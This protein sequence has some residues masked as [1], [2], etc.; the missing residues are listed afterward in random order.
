MSTK[1]G[2]PIADFETQLATQIDPAG[3][4]ATLQSATDDDGVALPAGRYFFTLDIGNS[5]KEHISCTLSGTSLTAIKSVSRQG[6]ETTGAARKH[7]VG[8]SVTITDYAHIKYMNDLLSGA[9]QLD[10]TSPLSYDG[11]ASITTANQLATKAY[12]DATAT[13]SATYDQDVFTGVAGETLVSGDWVYFKA[14]DQRWW[15]ADA[16]AVGTSLA[17]K[18]A[19]AQGSASAAGSL[20]LLGGG[21]IKNLSGLT[22]GASY[23]ISST[24]GS[25]T[26]TR[27]V[28]P[29][30]AR[31]VGRAV[32]AT[33][34]LVDIDNKPDGMSQS[35]SE[36]YAADT[37]GTDTYAITITPTPSALAN[38]NMFN[39]KAGTSN[40]GG[41][42]LNVNGLGA[43]A[44]KKNYNTALADNDI[45][46]GQIVTVIYDLSNDCFQMQ[47]Q[48][49]NSA[50]GLLTTSLLATES[51]SDRQAVSAYYYQADGGVTFDAK[52]VANG[53]AGAA[54]IAFTVA[55]Q[56]NRVLVVF[57]STAGGG[58]F[59]GGTVAY[60]GVSMTRQQTQTGGSFQRTSVYTLVAPA[61]GA[62][63]L[64]F[65]VPGSGA[66]EVS[67]YS[68]YNASQGAID[69]SA[70]AVASTQSVT[71]V[72]RGT[73]EVTGLDGA[74][75]PTGGTNMQNNQQTTSGQSV[76]HLFTGDSGHVVGILGFTT[77]AT[78]GTNVL[79]V[80]IAPVT[81]PSF[82]YVSKSS[83]SST[84]N[85]A[86]TNKYLTFLG[87]AQ[88][89]A[90]VGQSLMV[91]TDGIVTGLSGLTP[92]ATYFLAD[93]AGTIATTTGTNSKKIGIAL[94]TTTLLIKHDNS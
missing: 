62:N 49:A 76:A 43:K 53:G 54:S 69:N 50:I 36:I 72:A 92:L 70:S 81:A 19:V 8:A 77:A 88:A 25:I 17:V 9:T 73:V 56:S 90:T 84:T 37:V 26:A 89:G 28:A 27:P 93:S 35:M 23:Y 65:T 24:G 20:S 2:T 79:S 15:K 58:D 40:T 55:N 45:L 48:L 4:T 67:I 6:V 13:G 87:F 57:L 85:A 82:G 47:S 75:A 78:G 91:Q 10:S 60:N 86:N 5:V 44:I 31:F 71:A 66:Y 59:G 22:P 80:G 42:T 7:R 29:A 12:V 46:A 34:M 21:L 68:Y 3:T 41:A 51:I 64:T 16:D 94:S 38:G 1:L 14:S 63:N 83:A 74:S 52:A 33:N 39:F 18:I 32:S 61:T 30:F 11:T